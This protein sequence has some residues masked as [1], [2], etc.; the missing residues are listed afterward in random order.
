MSSTSVD[1]TNNLNDSKPGSSYRRFDFHS[2]LQTVSTYN[3]NISVPTTS[4]GKPLQTGLA[5][6]AD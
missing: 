4:A 1:K 3:A 2:N 6:P 5:T